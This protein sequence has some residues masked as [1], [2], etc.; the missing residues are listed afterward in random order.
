MKNHPFSL[1]RFSIVLAVIVSVLI[2]GSSSFFY[3]SS[4]KIYFGKIES[5]NIGLLPHENEGLIYIAEDQQ[6]FAA[7]GLNVSIKNYISGLAAV[8]GLLK[9]EVDIATAA[10]FVIVGKALL[11]ESIFAVGTIGKF[12]SEYVVARSDRGISSASDLK[13]KTIGVSRG[14]VA[15]FYLGRFLEL[16]LIKLSQVTL[17]NMSP[18]ETPTA[19]ANG[20]VDAV[21]AWQ[22]HID[23]IK[24][25]LGANAL[26]WPAQGNQQINYDAICTRTWAMSNPDLIRRFLKSLAQAEN[27]VIGNS[28]KS[29][30]IVQNRLNYTD[31]YI[32][33]VWPE[34]QFSLS[35]DQSFIVTMQDEA[36]WMINNKLTTANVVPNFL[37]YVYLNGLRA[38]KPESVNIIG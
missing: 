12:F 38:I 27:Y 2:V 13:N 21:I 31:A 24:S 23:T 20:T 34:Y 37:N 6:F 10:D 32:A 16:N 35:L 7:N 17:V 18:T 4:Q 9:G 36:R 3:L 11:N 8:D 15:E 19:L 14:T 1:R 29:K 26:V 25:L 28:E 22:P 30:I 5:I 33:T